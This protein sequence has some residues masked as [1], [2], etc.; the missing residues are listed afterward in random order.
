MG[1]LLAWPVFA[2]LWGLAVVLVRFAAMGRKHRE[3]RKNR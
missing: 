3:E 2:P 1:L